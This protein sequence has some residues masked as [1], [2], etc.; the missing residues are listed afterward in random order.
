MAYWYAGSMALRL[1]FCKKSSLHK[2]ENPKSTPDI[3]T[4]INLNRKYIQ[5]PQD[6]L[7]IYGGVL[8]QRKI[9]DE[10]WAFDMS[11]HV[12]A[13]ITQNEQQ[14]VDPKATTWPTTMPLA[15]AG[16]TAHVVGQK[17]LVIFGYCPTWGFTNV[18]QE[19][20]FGTFV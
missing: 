7:Y 10:F 17:M 16:H 12:W 15:V 2:F 11:A 6:S 5:H 18:V 9:T 1:F 14:H 19:Y 4:N 8:N 13:E 3:P 20:D